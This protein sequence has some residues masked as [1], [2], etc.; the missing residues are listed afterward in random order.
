MTKATE[1]IQNNL[2]FKPIKLRVIIKIRL[3][4]NR[5]IKEPN[6]YIPLCTLDEMHFTTYTA[7]I[8]SKKVNICSGENS[9]SG[10]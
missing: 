2:I 10:I 5:T 3:Y 9:Y 7:E 6:P 8:F 1:I 4:Q